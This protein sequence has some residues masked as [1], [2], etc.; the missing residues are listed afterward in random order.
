MMVEQATDSAFIKRSIERAL[1]DLPALPSV[2]A[3]V[4]EETERPEACAIDIERLISSDQAMASKVLR[5][6]NSAYYGMSG[7]VT[8]LSQ[9]IVI[10][11]LQQ[12]RNLVLSVGAISLMQPRTKRQQ[13]T[14]R[15]FWLHAFGTGAATQIIG[16]RKMFDSKDVEAMFVGGLLH[17]IGRLFLF[18]NFTQTYDEVIRYAEENQIRLEE[19]E[20]LLLGMHHGQ[21]GEAMAQQWRL[22]EALVTMIAH[23]EGP[24]SEEATSMQFCVH[25]GDHITKHLYFD[26]KQSSLCVLD[27]LALAWLDFSDEEYESLKEATQEKVEEA[28]QLF[29][30]SQAA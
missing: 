19:A 17:D 1:K 29:G 12:I 10:L 13:E 8:S 22:P 21:V 26:Q 6:V 5:V 14:L 3:K 20:V 25:I 9:A 24:F 30:L 7:R 18:S 28:A 16:K 11:G 4:L 27:P 2:V 23:H 15:Q